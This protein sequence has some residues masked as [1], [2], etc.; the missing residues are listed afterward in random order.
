MYI[1]VLVAQFD[2][3]KKKK[4]SSQQKNKMQD[5]CLRGLFSVTSVLHDIWVQVLLSVHQLFDRLFS[6]LLHV[7][8]ILLVLC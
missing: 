7:S 1:T 3:N 5:V 2:K 6:L 4:H 8:R